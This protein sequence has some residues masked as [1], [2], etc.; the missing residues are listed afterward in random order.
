MRKHASFHRGSW[1]GTFMHGISRIDGRR[2]NKTQLTIV[3]GMYE[4]ESGNDKLPIPN[5]MYFTEF[6]TRK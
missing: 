4:F 1:L 5:K 3:S 6:I 2:N